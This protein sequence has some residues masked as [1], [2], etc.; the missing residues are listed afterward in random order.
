VDGA[1][2]MYGGEKRC[3]QSFGGKTRGKV[4]TCRHWH[5]WK[6]SVKMDLLEVGYEG[7]DLNDVAHDRDRCRHFRVKC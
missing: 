6:G 5:R 7:M 3:T 4:T 2:S 1:C